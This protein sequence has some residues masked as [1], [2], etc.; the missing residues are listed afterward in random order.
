MCG[1]LA[2]WIVPTILSP[3]RHAWKTKC[4]DPLSKTRV[5]VTSKVHKLSANPILQKSLEFPH[6]H[7]EQLGKLG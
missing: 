1:H 5:Q 6:I 2:G 4:R 7:I 3:E